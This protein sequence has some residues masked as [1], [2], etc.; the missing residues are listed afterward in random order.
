MSASK[1]A[2][3]LSEENPDWLNN[4]TKVRCTGCNWRG[5]LHQL[6][7]EPDNETVYC[8]VCETS[9]WVWGEEDPPKKRRRR[10]R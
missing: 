4:H 6:L 3:P 5:E 7:C 2:I 1:T 10:K 8:P 9:G